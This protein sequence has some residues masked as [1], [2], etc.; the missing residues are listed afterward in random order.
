M[1]LVNRFIEGSSSAF[2]EIYSLHFDRVF[3]ISLRYLRDKDIAAD[4]TQDVFF[5]LWRN[6]TK[7]SRE[8]PL[9]QQLYVIT[10]GMVIDHFR[11]IASEEKLLIEFKDTLE[12]DSGEELEQEELRLGWQKE[13][14]LKRIYSLVEQL[15]KKQK[16]VF[17]MFKYEGLTYEEIASVL[18]VSPNTV[19]NHLSSALKSIKKKIVG[20][21]F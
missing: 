16:E 2:E 6:K 21:I 3:Y 18:N 17:K 1:S 20:F 19:S 15:P 5:K 7:V 12:D 8:I 11:K 10:K 13:R 14:R 9:E 4:I